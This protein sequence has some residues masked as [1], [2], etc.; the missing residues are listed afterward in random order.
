MGHRNR[1][2]GQYMS[3][4]FLMG[5]HNHHLTPSLDSPLPH[6]RKQRR[7]ATARCRRDEGRRRQEQPAGGGSRAG[8]ASNRCGG[9]P[10]AGEGVEVWNH[11]R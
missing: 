3:S 11:S 8:D 7:P 10:T 2:M 4:P 1:N 5:R 6:A 9:G